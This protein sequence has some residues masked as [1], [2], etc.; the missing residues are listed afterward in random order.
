M[1]LT[2]GDIVDSIR[3]TFD[4]SRTNS[5]ELVESLLGIVKSTLEKGDGVL[6][7]SFGT[8]C[9]KNKR[10][11]KGISPQTGETLILRPR[12]VVTFKCSTVL[13]DKMN[14]KRRASYFHVKASI[15]L[16]Y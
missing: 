11:R 13:R 5:G 3:T 2:K 15:E 12:T 6:I 8:F 7:S 10:K 16:P 4:F 1:T 9:V 14:N